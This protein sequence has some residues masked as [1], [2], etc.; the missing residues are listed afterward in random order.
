MLHI[1]AGRKRTTRLLL[2]IL[3]PQLNSYTILFKFN[4]LLNMHFSILM[5]A[6]LTAGFASAICPGFNYGIGNQQK[7][8]DEITRWNVYDDSCNVVDSLTTTENPCTQ[9]IFGCTPA[10]IKFNAYKNTF[11]GLR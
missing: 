9:G 3:C 6:P 8:N 11:S 10:P 1:K 4:K 7:L 5:L 2:I